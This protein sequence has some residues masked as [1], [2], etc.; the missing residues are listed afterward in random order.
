MKNDLILVGIWLI[1]AILYIGA[2]SFILVAAGAVLAAAG[3]LLFQTN[4]IEPYLA[5]IE[6]FLEEVL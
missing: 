6:N 4:L 1:D 2:I 3:S 5:M